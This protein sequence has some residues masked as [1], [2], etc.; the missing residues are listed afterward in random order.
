MA[1]VAIALRIGVR[2]AR[3]VT[4]ERLERVDVVVHRRPR[5][6]GRGHGQLTG[7]S[8]DEVAAVLGFELALGVR[9]GGP[10]LPAE[11]LPHAT[12]ATRD[13]GGAHCYHQD[14]Q[15]DDKSRHAGCRYCGRLA[16]HCGVGGCRVISST[17]RWEEI[18]F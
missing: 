5:H 8:G 12:D 18:L 11:G 10:I 17:L 13:N 7:R 6:G 14:A 1:N 9:V 15:E 3:L 16:S 4:G 2:L